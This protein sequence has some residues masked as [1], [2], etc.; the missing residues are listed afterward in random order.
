MNVN[1]IY[2]DLI[3]PGSAKVRD[4]QTTEEQSAVAKRKMSRLGW[5]RDGYSV[6]FFAALKHKFGQLV[7]ECVEGTDTMTEQELRLRLKQAQ[8]IKDTIE[9]DYEQLDKVN[10]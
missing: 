3:D 9:G 8:T 6:T 1:Q 5:E 7:L 4:A 10:A 2:Q